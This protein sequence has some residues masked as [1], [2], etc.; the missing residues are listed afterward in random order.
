MFNQTFEHLALP[1]AVWKER[2]YTGGN[3]NFL[4]GAGGFL[5]NLIFGYGGLRIE[6]DQLK[7]Y[8]PQLPPLPVPVT[9]LTLRNIQ[10]HGLPFTMRWTSTTVVFTTSAHG[11]VVID[12]QGN[13]HSLTPSNPVT[14]PVGAYS[15]MSHA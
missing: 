4:T 9:A 10:Y 8:P 2:A 1:F 3:L 13:G 6:T 7:V 15:I 14:L 12:A 11:L 5:Q